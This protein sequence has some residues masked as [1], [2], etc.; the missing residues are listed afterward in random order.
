[1]YC[2]GLQY[3]RFQ[4]YVIVVAYVGSHV[5]ILKFYS[6]L[7]PVYTGY[8]LIRIGADGDG[9]YLV[10]NCIEGIAACLSPGTGGDATLEEE[11]YKKYGIKSILCDPSHD[12]PEGLSRNLSFDK[13]KLARHT[14]L[15]SNSISM[16]DW[17]KK[18]KLSES[19]PLMLSMDIEGGEYEVIDSLEIKDISKFR[20]VVME[21]H[22]LSSDF[23]LISADSL[24]KKMLDIF[25]I[26]H[27]RPNNACNLKINSKSFCYD[28]YHALDITFLSKYMRKCHP[29]QVE[30]LPHPLDQNHVLPG[31]WFVEGADRVYKD[32]DYS[33]YEE[34]R[35]FI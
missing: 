9:G 29:R 25:D 27:I 34:S 28:Y 8:E 20:I 33:F 22:A 12:R 14:S 24:I 31:T 2:N 26:V 15:E 11:I 21:L 17:L 5:D 7:W 19:L 13:V 30:S 23:G 16:P 3:I 32:I 10:P 35:K 4:L 1:M 6:K 18:Y